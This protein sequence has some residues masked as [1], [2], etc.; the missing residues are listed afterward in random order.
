MLE[1][2]N[3]HIPKTTQETYQ[4]PNCKEEWL[5]F[6][7]LNGYISKGICPNCESKKTSVKDSLTRFVNSLMSDRIE[8]FKR[9]G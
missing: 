9:E 2:I 7:T 5:K 4:C 6:P 8:K 1:R 3:C